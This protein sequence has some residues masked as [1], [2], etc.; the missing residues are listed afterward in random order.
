MLMFVSVVVTTAI[1]VVTFVMVVVVMLVFVTVVM[2]TAIGV[3]T[4]VMVVVVMML[5][6]MTVVMTTA[7][8]IV[9]FTVMMFVMMAFRFRRQTVKFGL[10]A[11]LAFHCS[12]NILAVK[13][14]PFCGDYGCGGI[15]FFQQSDR[16]RKLFFRSF[17]RVG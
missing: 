1:G 3:V 7:I 8:G 4:F 15:F 14:R 17:T 16:R 12:K 13:L 11:V 2:T 5:V 9:T 10:Q 6:F